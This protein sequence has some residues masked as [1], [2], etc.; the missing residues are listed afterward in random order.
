MNQKITKIV[1][2][3]NITPDSFFDGAKYNEIE[4]ALE[5]L[6]TLINNGADIID[7]GAESTR[8]GAKPIDAFEEWQRLKDVLPQAIKYV[9]NY[10]QQNHRNIQISLDSRHYQTI[11]KALDLG[12][13]IIN[14]VSGCSD[15]RMIDLVAKSG[16]KIVVMHNLGIPADKNKIINPDLD[17]VMAL[18]DWMKDRLEKLQL[19]GIKKG[20]IIFDIG[21]GFGK[22]AK[23]SIQLLQQIDQFKILD[24]PLY[25]GHS[26]K[27]FLNYLRF[28]GDSSFSFDDQNPSTL[29]T[30]AKT[31][32]ISAYL[33]RKNVEYLRV[34]DVLRNIE[35]RRKNYAI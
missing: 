7:I 14:D 30:E 34:H 21:I 18:I 17:V 2:I 24:L 15:L 35:D 19:G 22:N 6:K 12:I 11:A 31:F 3:L 28:N 25:V 20:Q 33:A 8:P 16:K 9:L 27:S 29:S 13:D 4:N 26:N 23:Q 10:N 5:H 32:M 1:G